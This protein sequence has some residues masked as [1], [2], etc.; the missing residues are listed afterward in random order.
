MGNDCGS[1][2]YKVKLIYVNHRL[3]DIEAASWCPSF[4][5]TSGDQIV[6]VL[7]NVMLLTYIKDLKGVELL[8]SFEM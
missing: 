1:T 6:T 7:I 5:Y 3:H 8:N 2:A 4:F